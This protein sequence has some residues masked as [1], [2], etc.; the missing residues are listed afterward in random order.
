MEYVWQQRKMLPVG[1]KGALTIAARVFRSE[2]ANRHLL[3]TSTGRHQI[4][5]ACDDVL[6]PALVSFRPVLC[7]F[8]LM[9]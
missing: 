4:T 2:E 8:L 7:H 6:S 3:S 5:C 9:V 1:I